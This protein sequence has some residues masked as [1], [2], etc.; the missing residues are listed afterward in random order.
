MQNVA[1]SEVRRDGGGVLYVCVR[2]Q[3]AIGMSRDPIEYF[4][5][6]LGMKE[7]QVG[8]GIESA[9]VMRGRGITGGKDDGCVCVLGEGGG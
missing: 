3:G 2:P 5:R 8:M 7:G 9:G 1:G 4:K 6:S